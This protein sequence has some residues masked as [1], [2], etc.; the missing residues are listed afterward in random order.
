MSLISSPDERHAQA[1]ENLRDLEFPGSHALQQR[2]SASIQL[3]GFDGSAFESIYGRQRVQT[4]RQPGI[5]TR[6]CFGVSESLLEVR[7]R[8]CASSIGQSLSAGFVEVDPT[9]FCFGNDLEQN[10]SVPHTNR[11]GNLDR[12]N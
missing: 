9:A 11:I 5:T 12:P 7:Y 4:P 8:L 10:I 3:F 1:A 2:E 6:G